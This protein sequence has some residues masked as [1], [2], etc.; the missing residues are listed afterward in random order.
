MK[1]DGK[2]RLVNSSVTFCLLPLILITQNID[3]YIDPGTGSLIIQFLIASLVGGLFL[4]KVF[5]AKIK[6]FFSNLSSKAR[7]GNG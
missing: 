6:A 5:W 4:I 1:N 3:A 7:K 2:T